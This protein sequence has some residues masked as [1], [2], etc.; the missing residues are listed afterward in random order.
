MNEQ[1]C[2]SQGKY[3]G[4]QRCSRGIFLGGIL[5]SFIGSFN[6]RA[7]VNHT[8]FKPKSPFKLSK[9]CKLPADQRNSL[10]APIPQKM[11][12][13]IDSTFDKD[14]QKSVAAAALAWN[15][16]GQKIMGDD[17]F[18]YDVGT[19]PDSVAKMTDFNSSVP[20]GGL[21]Y[22]YVVNVKSNKL[23]KQM[24]LGSSES[25]SFTPGVVHSQTDPMPSFVF[26][27]QVVELDTT[28]IDGRQFRSL[29]L[30][31][32][33]HALGLLHSCQNNAALSSK[34]YVSCKNVPP[35]SAYRLAVMYP[36]FKSEGPDGW[37]EEKTTPATIRHSAIRVSLRPQGIRPSGASVHQ[38]K[39]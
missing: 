17:F 10:R 37:P 26:Y 30:H 39:I 6:A 21:D 2:S 9:D 20:Y 1:G 36:V 3:G 34:D 8:E 27:Q 38:V 7:E 14:E 32:L 13:I 25:G 24:G 18:T 16:V 15:K 33:G 23:W 19:V 5:L 4:E 31:E 29:A 11:H 12:L 35:N 22:T 28:L